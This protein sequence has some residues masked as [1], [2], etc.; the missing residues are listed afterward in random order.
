MGDRLVL[1]NTGSFMNGD[2]FPDFYP[3]GEMGK[4]ELGIWIQKPL[5]GLDLGLGNFAYLAWKKSGVIELIY[6]LISAF[7]AYACPEGGFSEAF[8]H[9]R[10][11]WAAK[12]GTTSMRQIRRLVGK[13]G[14]LRT[15]DTSY[16][17]Y[18]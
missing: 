13:L 6:I 3:M 5:A 14:T 4:W 11:N 10:T 16:I 15:V 1:I 2:I 17:H 18:V 12:L 8:V 7:L 9:A